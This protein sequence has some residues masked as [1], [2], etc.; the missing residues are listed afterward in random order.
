[1]HVLLGVGYL[2]QDDILK[3]YPF[4]SKIHDTFVFNSG[5][6]FHC[7]D[8]HI[9]LIHSSVEENLG[10]L[11]FLAVMNKAAR[12]IVLKVSLWYS[13]SSYAYMSRN[14]ISRY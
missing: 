9:F 14:V 5:L 11:Q 1:M 4:A 12:N 6:I 10:C 2:T 13:T 8:Y 3:I 7:I